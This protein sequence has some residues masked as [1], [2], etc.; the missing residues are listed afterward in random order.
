MK[1]MGTTGS[2]GDRD[3]ESYDER[4]T[5]KSIDRGSPMSVWPSTKND[6][7]IRIDKVRYHSIDLCR[8]V[9]ACNSFPTLYRLLIIMLNHES[10]IRRVTRLI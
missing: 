5:N 3:D 1:A 10:L 9:L 8:V 7:N 4:G 6:K 2:E